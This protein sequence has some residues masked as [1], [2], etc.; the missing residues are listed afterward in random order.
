MSATQNTCIVSWD[1]SATLYT[2]DV[3][4]TKFCIRC[5]HIISELGVGADLKV[6]DMLIVCTNEYQQTKMPW[7]SFPQNWCY[8]SSKTIV[9]YVALVT[10]ICCLKHFNVWTYFDNFQQ[11]RTCCRKPY[12]CI[13]CNIIY[14]WDFS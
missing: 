2:S 8:C 9:K 3:A 7:L 6:F 5:L 10:K 14:C 13:K 4:D 11:E 1:F 12:R